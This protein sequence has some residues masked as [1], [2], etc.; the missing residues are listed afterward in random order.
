ML[1][2]GALVRGPGKHL[3]RELLEIVVPGVD[4]FGAE[5]GQSLQARSPADG[6][7]VLVEYGVERWSI[8]RRLKD[9]VGIVEERVDGILQRQARNDLRPPVAVVAGIAGDDLA[10]AEILLVDRSEER[11]V[12]KECG[13]WW[14]A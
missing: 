12:G 3:H 8:E 6:G 1:N 5:G 11:R 7:D 13:A 10:A 9:L 4:A 14:S 2:R